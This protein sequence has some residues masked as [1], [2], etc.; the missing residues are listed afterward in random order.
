MERTG[1]WGTSPRGLHF[2]AVLGRMLLSEAGIISTR[3]FHIN[4][5]RISSCGR[6][7]RKKDWTD[8][9]VAARTSFARGTAGDG[10]APRRH[11]LEA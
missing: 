3:S 11:R 7:C 8:M 10:D 1:E 6:K 5:R 4:G 2:S 9:G